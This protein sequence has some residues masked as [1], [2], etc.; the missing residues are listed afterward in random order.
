[1]SD[2]PRPGFSRYIDAIAAFA[3]QQQAKAVYCYVIDGALG[4]GGCPLVMHPAATDRAEYERCSRELIAMMR[5]SADLFE[6]DL[7]RQGLR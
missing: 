6:Q 7:E 1:M 4:T 2:Y 3:K 5:R